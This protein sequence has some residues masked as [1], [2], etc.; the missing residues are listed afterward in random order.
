[1]NNTK[2]YFVFISYSSKDNEDDNKWAEWLRHELDTWHL[3]STY[4]GEKKDVRD[5]LREVFR[6]RDGFSAGKDWWEQAKEKLKQSQNLIVICSP[7]AKKSD[8]VKQ[9]IDYFI[10]D[11][12]NGKDDNVFPFIIE[13]EGPG[14]CFP[15]GLRDRKVGGDVNKD[16]GR[17]NAFLKIVAGILGVEFSD[18][19]NRY[20]LEKI[21]QERIEREKKEKLLIAQSRFVVEKAEKLLSEGDSNLS[22]LLALKVLPKDVS[23]P[24]RPYTPEAE[25][26]LRNAES[27]N[28]SL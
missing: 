15:E 24:D 14:D 11:V 1:M 18:L 5:N 3:P 2:K 12:N 26:L 10:N 25:F 22:K 6:D 7:N 19:R 23:N 17:D 28:C 21:E 13:G 4:N 8:A 9:E 20:Q 27:C 16:E